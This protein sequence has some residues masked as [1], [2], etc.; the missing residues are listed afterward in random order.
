LLNE[1]EVFCAVGV[2]QGGLGHMRLAVVGWRT[3]TRN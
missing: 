2:G 1:Y 3:V